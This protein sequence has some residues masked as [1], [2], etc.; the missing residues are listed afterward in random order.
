MELVRYSPE[1]LSA[2][3]KA[4]IEAFSTPS[5][6][7]QLSIGNFK[8]RIENKLNLVPD[9][10]YL[11]L[12]HNQVIGFLLQTI[13]SYEK[14]NTLYNGG[15]GIIPSRRRKGYAGGLL[16]KG[17]EEAAIKENLSRSM[18]EVVDD[19]RPGNQLYE[20]FGFQ[21][22]RTLKCFKLNSCPENSSKHERWILKEF[23][24]SKL[25]LVNHL[26]SYVPAF[27]D[28]FEQLL[29]NSEYERFLCL[30]NKG[31]IMGYIIFQ[32]KTGRISQLVVNRNYRGKGIGRHLVA[33]AWTRSEPNY[34]TLMN[35]PETE[36]ETL[37]A[38]EKIGFENQID[39]YEMELLI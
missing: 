38:L 25:N 2:L 11:L 29:K 39:Q 34:L 14:K 19:N 15:I 3:H 5:L 7:V 24:L 8:V 16:E 30:E 28:S 31:E 32:P 20:S 6:K 13:N 36:T 1:H 35:I 18:L 22:R 33:E 26:P 27:I 21:Y 17:L 37:E 9:Y 4:F 10:S 12:Q 23:P